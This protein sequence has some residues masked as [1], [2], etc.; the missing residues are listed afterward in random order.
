MGGDD[1]FKDM[2]AFYVLL[3][4]IIYAVIFTTQPDPTIPVIQQVVVFSA[5][6]VFGSFV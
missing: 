2:V 4:L 1:R 5:L 6:L 3:I